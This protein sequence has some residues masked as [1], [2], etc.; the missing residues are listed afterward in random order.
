[1]SSPFR[2]D[3]PGAWWHLTNRG[4]AKRAVFET[5]EDVERFCATLASVIAEG[6]LEIHAH[7]FLTTHYHLLARSPKGEISRAMKLVVN[8]F[9]R[10][11]NRARRRDGALFRG[12]FKGRRIDDSDYWCNVL[13]YIDLNPVRA[14]LCKLPSDHPF[15]SARAYRYGAGPQWLSRVVGQ[16]AE[17]RALTEPL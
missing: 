10:W 1:M 5:I 6:L 2:D 9:V 3:Y 17:P 7:S 13:R 15:G 16:F 4:I 14:G 8:E 12:P 11:F